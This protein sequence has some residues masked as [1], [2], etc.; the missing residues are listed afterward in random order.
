[1][2]AVVAELRN[3]EQGYVRAVNHGICPDPGAE[4]HTET[5]FPECDAIARRAGAVVCRGESAAH[6]R[7][8]QNDRDQDCRRRVTHR[9]LA[10]KLD[11]DHVRTASA[12]LIVRVAVC[13]DLYRRG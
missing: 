6:V 10:V 13:S 12:R 4:G 8:T 3:D 1:M 5:P 2:L 11:C 9:V 7:E